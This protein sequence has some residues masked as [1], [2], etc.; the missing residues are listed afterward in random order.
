MVKEPQIDRHH[1]VDKDKITH[2]GAG[3]VAAVLAKQLDPALGRKLMELVVGHAGHAALVLFVPAIHVEIAKTHHLAGFAQH[4]ALEICTAFASHALVKQQL[5]VA[6]DVQRTLKRRFFT[7]GVRAAIGGRAGGVQQPGTAP[8]TGVEQAAG[9][10]VVVVHH[11]LAVVLH[12]VAAGALMENGLNLAIAAVRKVLVKGA[13]IHIIGN[14][15]TGQVAELV[16]L[17][18][19]IHGDHIIDSAGV[20]APNDVAANKA[21]G[22]GDNDAG[23]ANNSS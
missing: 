8:L 11:V 21:G 9:Q 16:A 15:Q 6:V 5:G 20:Q 12:G 14:L 3:A 18:Q 1:V 17:G 19:V 7:E 2:L 22:A 10:A 4:R 23:H 13:R